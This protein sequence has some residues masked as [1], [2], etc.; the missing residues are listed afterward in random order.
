ME[1]ISKVEVLESKAPVQPVVLYPD[2]EDKPAA[3]QVRV[4]LRREELLRLL[5]AGHRVKECAEILRWSTQTV[6]GEL[7]N[8]FFRNRLRLVSLEIYGKVDEELATLK[9][10]PA[11]RLSEMADKALDQMELLLDSSDDRIKL[12]VSQD[13][14]DRNMETSKTRR[15]EKSSRSL[16]V[17]IELLAR[18]QKTAE[19]VSEYNQHPRD[20]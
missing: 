16:N 7:A 10:D 17:N 14:L 6:R 9:T 13:V 3:L 4:A 18:A 19:E 5:L 8:V 2:L 12:R 15:L 11:T 20:S 1:A